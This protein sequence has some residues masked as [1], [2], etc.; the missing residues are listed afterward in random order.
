[1]VAA[2]ASRIFCGIGD[3]IADENPPDANFGCGICTLGLPRI[4]ACGPVPLI[5]SAIIAGPRAEATLGSIIGYDGRPEPVIGSAII[6]AGRAPVDPG[7]AI[8]SAWRAPVAPGSDTI[9]GRAP[10]DPGSDI[11]AAPRF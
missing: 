1:M 8:I 3:V 6:I 5:G 7:S 4:A 10:V 9:A 11:P 2:C